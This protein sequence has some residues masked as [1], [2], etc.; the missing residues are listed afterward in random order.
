MRRK[1]FCTLVIL[2][3]LSAIGQ[4][5]FSKTQTITLTGLEGDAPYP[6]ASG[7]ID[8]DGFYDIVVG[9]DLGGAIFWFKND[10]LGN[11]TQQSTVANNLARV[12]DIV[13]VDINGDTTLDILASSFNDDKV[14]YYPN[15]LANPGTFGSEITI[16]S[17][18][19]GATDLDVVL[20][21]GDSLL[22][23]VVSAFNADKIVW[24]AGNGDGTFGTENIM[25][26]SIVNPASFDLKDINTDGE[27]DLVVANA[28]NIGN[29][30]GLNTSV[31][32]VFFNSGL[33]FTKDTN[34]VANDKD[35]LFHASFEDI[36][37]SNNIGITSDILA[38]DLY[39][40]LAHYNRNALGN[41]D[42]TLIPTTITNP[43][44]VAM[45]NIDA[46]VDGFK[47]IILASG[48]NGFGN[49]LVWFKNNGSGNFS[50]ESVIDNTQSNAYKFT[51]A[52]FDNDGDLDIA[53]AAYG[54]DQI[55]IFNNQKFVL[56]TEDFQVENFRMYPNPV[57]DV[58]QFETSILSDF[59]YAIYTVLGHKL[60]EGSLRPNAT[61]DVTR[62]KSGIYFFELKDSGKVYKFIKK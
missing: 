41:Y 2:A 25:I 32:E 14:V 21:N 9:T 54:D 44:S 5:T 7:D 57:I 61:I 29:D 1:I 58:L 23:I 60:M 47:D 22:D 48:E 3:S 20:L 12:I 39:G 35:Y 62:L 40:D 17:A 19:D 33:T 28:I 26:N 51:V 4:T 46:S 18:I 10:G 30:P 52:D 15:N 11:F 27:L 45:Y 34:S 31:I 24:F 49:D 16:A 59:G 38:T 43:A 8:K 6:I 55:N 13:L 42:E 50:A 56:N 37:A 53:T 36:D